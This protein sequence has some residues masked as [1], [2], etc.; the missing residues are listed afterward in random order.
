MDIKFNADSAEELVKKMDSYCTAI[1]YDAKELLDIVEYN[2]E[3]D[4]SQNKYF[5][6][7]I[8]AISEDLCQALQMESDYRN[9]FSER[10]AELRG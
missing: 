2:G 6:E 3:W 7:T 1:F 5:Y 4:D 8:S 10:I 9:L